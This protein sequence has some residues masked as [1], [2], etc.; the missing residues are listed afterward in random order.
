M[1][2]VSVVISCYNAAKSVA[3]SVNSMREQTLRDIEIILINDGSKDATLEV[4]RD[5]AAQDDRIRVIDNVENIGLSAS[6]NR[7]IRA[8]ESEL[9]ARM[10]AD[11]FALPQRLERQYEFMMEHRDVDICGTGMS[12][13][14]DEQ[15]LRDV[16]LPELHD[17]I[18]RQVY[19]KPLVYHPTVMIKRSVYDEQGYYDPQLRWA[20]DADLWM[21]IYDKVKFHN[22]QEPLLHYEL[23]P[24][25]TSRMMRK[26][27]EV[28]YTNLK[29]RG[30]V[31]Q[32][33][34]ILAKDLLTMS[35]K[36]IKNW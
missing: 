13:Y 36:M 5:L 31:L 2:K 17:D 12:L 21:R 33:A 24:R 26:N 10:D 28:K 35:L 20:E 14:R 3:K 7:G 29:R 4:L 34:P 15:H 27:L 19:I 9:I 16:A 22:L 6:L 11:D 30:K 1:P 8:A 32:Y 25:L 23:K 18:V